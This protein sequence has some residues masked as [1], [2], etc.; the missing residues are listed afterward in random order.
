M[1]RGRGLGKEPSQINDMPDPGFPRRGAEAERRLPIEIGEIPAA[2]HGVDQVIGGV[3][4]AQGFLEPGARA[5][6][7]ARDLDA[8]RPGPADHARGVA[9]QDP[10]DAVGREQA[11]HQPP[12]DIARS[13]RDQDR[14]HPMCESLQHPWRG[15][16][17]CPKLPRARL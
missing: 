5:Q 10:D 2:E 9:D 15:G 14:F 6:V 13:T 16:E 1:L 11:R 3:D 7:R 8:T 4:S 12:A 17:E